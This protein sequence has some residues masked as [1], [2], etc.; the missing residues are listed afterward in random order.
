[1]T[2]FLAVKNNAVSSLNGDISDSVQT[3]TLASGEGA[4]FPDGSVPFHVSIDDEIITVGARSSDVL[5]SLTR[6]AE[7]TTAVAHLE[8]AAVELRFTAEQMEDIHAAIAA[9]EATTHSDADDHDAAHTLASHTT[10]AHSELS[11]APKDAHHRAFVGVNSA[12]PGVSDRITV[13]GGD[14]ITVDEPVA[15]TVRLTHGTQASGDS[16]PEYQKESEANVHGGY[17]DAVGQ[18]HIMFT[19]TQSM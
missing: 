18:I 7:S 17:G 4:K 19:G 12:D 9:L 2:T 8:A 1:M 3:L 13:A 11:D 6:G 14:G 10:K 15:S 5:S 16:H